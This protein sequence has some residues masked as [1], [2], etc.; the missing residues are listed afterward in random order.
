M[1][2][3]VTKTYIYGTT[4]FS[5]NLEKFY[6]DFDLE[7]KYRVQQSYIALFTL[8]LENCAFMQKIPHNID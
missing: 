6:V 8:I 1:L 5:I 7:G 4:N 3:K 2:H